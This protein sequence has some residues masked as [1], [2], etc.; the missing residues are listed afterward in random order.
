MCLLYR[1][2]P[3]KSSHINVQHRSFKTSAILC[4]DDNNNGDSSNNSEAAAL[5]ILEQLN[6][7]DLHKQSILDM[8]TKIVNTIN[9]PSIDTKME[10]AT[11]AIEGDPKY[12][13]FPLNNNTVGRLLNHLLPK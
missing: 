12:A 10:V 3:L 7:L 6:T 5:T 2:L 9:D 8:K 4:T 1:T 13:K 11:K